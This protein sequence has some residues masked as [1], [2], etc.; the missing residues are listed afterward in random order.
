MN[1]V[2]WEIRNFRKYSD[3]P[4][5]TGIFR[6]IPEYSEACAEKFSN[7]KNKALSEVIGKN[8]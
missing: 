8:S 3:V 7:K 4:K 1:G 2:R 6:T 5:Y